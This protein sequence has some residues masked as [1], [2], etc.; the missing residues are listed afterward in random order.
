MA[1]SRYGTSDLGISA[2]DPLS[3]KHSTHFVDID[4][5]SWKIEKETKRLQF[6]DNSEKGGQ[7]LGNGL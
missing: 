4:Y 6:R 3:F 1:A 7:E 5:H 2:Y